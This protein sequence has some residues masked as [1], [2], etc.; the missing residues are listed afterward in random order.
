MAFRWP[1]LAGLPAAV[2][3]RARDI[4]ERL[5]R[6]DQGALIRSKVAND[7]PLFLRRGANSARSLQISE[8]ARRLHAALAG[9]RS[10]RYDPTRE[11]LDQ[12][13]ALKASATRRG[14]DAIDGATGRRP[15]SNRNSRQWTVPARVTKPS[16]RR[17][18]VSLP[19]E[20]IADAALG[21]CPAEPAMKGAPPAARCWPISSQV[22]TEGR[23]AIENGPSRRRQGPVAAQRAC[24]SLQDNILRALF[25]VAAGQLYRAVNPSSA[26][27]L[28]IVAVGGY[29]RGT[30]APGSDIDLLF[31]LPYKQTAWGE[32]VV[33]FIL[34]MLWD[35]GPES[36]PCHARRR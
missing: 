21:A 31:L 24:R 19:A 17:R 3:H 26:E 20:Q 11:A 32:S 7:L 2:V 28:S 15:E 22:Q 8:E 6:A 13:Y 25:A 4:L 23:A 18:T 5:E 34:Y 12:L 10:G 29:G 35:H 30:L 14:P 36:G 27:Q 1:K 33:E 9:T 16:S